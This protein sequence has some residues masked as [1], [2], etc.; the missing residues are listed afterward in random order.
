LKVTINQV[1]SF[2]CDPPY[3]GVHLCFGFRRSSARVS[4]GRLI[5][6]QFTTRI[7]PSPLTSNLELIQRR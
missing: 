5:Y 7:F 3:S 1:I 4:A 2:L 6:S